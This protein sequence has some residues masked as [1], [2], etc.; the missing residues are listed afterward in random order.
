MW[1]MF[2]SFENWQSPTIDGLCRCQK[3]HDAQN[4]SITVNRLWAANDTYVST[5]FA[6]SGT[7]VSNVA[8][9]APME[10]TKLPTQ[11]KWHFYKEPYIIL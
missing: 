2:K 5:H 11:I 8:L 7:Y 10:R 6:L 4:P 3:I 9:I 1:K